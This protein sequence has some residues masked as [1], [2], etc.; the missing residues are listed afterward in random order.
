MNEPTIT[1]HKSAMY[2]PIS[3]ELALDYGLI[4]EEQARAQGWTPAPP[5]PP[6]PRAPW[7]RRARWRP[8]DWRERIALA[9]FVLRGGD[10]HEDCER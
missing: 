7:W 2:V 3:T 8:A 6:V 9:W 1:V 5:A 4:T 10:M